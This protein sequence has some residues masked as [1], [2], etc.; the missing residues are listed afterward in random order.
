MAK[1][2]APS[3]RGRRKKQRNKVPRVSGR[4]KSLPPDATAI[5]GWLPVLLVITGVL[6]FGNS[7]SG[8]FIID[9]I[10]AIVENDYIRHLWPPSDMLSGPAQTSVAGRPVVSLSLAV[11]YALGGLD[12]EGYHVVNVLLHVLCALVLF[13]IVRRTL[14]GDHLRARFGRGAG[15]TAM[16]CALIWMV[17]PL[18]TETVNYIIQ[19]TESLMGLFYLLTVYCAIRASDSARRDWWARTCVLCCALGMSSKEVMV[20]APL[21][22]LLYDRVFRFGSFEVAWRERRRLYLGLAATWGILLVLVWSGP[23]SHTAGFSTILDVTPWSYFLNQSRVIVEYLRLA[24]WPRGLVV[25]YGPSESVSVGAVAPHLMAVAGLLAGTVVALVYRP[26]VGFLGA[27][28]FVI[29]APTTSIVP[30]ATE[31]AAERRV[32]LPLAGLVVLV[33]VLGRILLERRARQAKLPAVGPSACGGERAAVIVVAVAL[34]VTTMSRNVDYRS[35][36]SLWRT[37]VDRQPENWGA[38]GGLGLALHAAGDTDGAIRHF[39]QSLA[40]NPDSPHVNSNLGQVLLE[41][42]RGPEAIVFLRRALEYDVRVARPDLHRA[43]GLSLEAADRVDEAVS[44]YRQA[45]ELSPDFA[46]AHYN[47]GNTLGRQGN[48]DQAISH[49]RHALRLNPDYAQAHHNLGDTLALSDDLD[50]A[51]QHFR[52]AVRVDPDLAV[53]WSRMAE[54]VGGHPDAD[55]RDPGQAVTFAQRAAELTRY[56]NPSVLLQLAE[57]HGLAGQFSEAAETAQTA[58]AVLDELPTTPERLD[59]TNYLRERVVAYGAYE[60]AA[61]PR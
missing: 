29:L 34:A 15:G 28:F 4:P 21:M 61:Q 22:V 46:E 13:G 36:E 19:R 17:H 50:G 9:D 7:L 8:P 43:L 20:T 40:I 49:F 45:L 56:E 57:L 52:A 31:V 3:Q 37:V 5:V 58:L 35:V 18:Q 39:R 16:A 6:V 12:V 51:L 10:S 25:Y 53:T 41:Q 32:Y 14:V 27:W 24:V 48:L 44:H 33:V 42:E 11:N 23:R 38:L 47:L 55:V 2:Y 59:L 54:I 60:Q 26:A 1:A 30:I